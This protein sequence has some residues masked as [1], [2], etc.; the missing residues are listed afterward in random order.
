LGI[1]G[2]PDQTT[3]ICPITLQVED[4]GLKIQRFGHRGAPLGSKIV[5]KLYHPLLDG[6]AGVNQL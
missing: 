2:L 3:L 4:H 1:V 6:T 5:S